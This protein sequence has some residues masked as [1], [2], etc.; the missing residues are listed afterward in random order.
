MLAVTLA[1]RER[2][3][4]RLVLARLPV[5]LLVLV[6]PALGACRSEQS[7]PESLSCATCVST[8]P[9]ACAW[10]TYFDGTGRCDSSSYLV[11]G[12][13][14]RITRTSPSCEGVTTDAG[15]RDAGRR[16]DGCTPPCSS[17]TVCASVSGT[18]T[19]LET[20]GSHAECS[21]GC[22]ASLA[23]GQRACAPSMSWCASCTCPDGTACR[24]DG[25]CPSSG[26]QD[27]TACVNFALRSQSVCGYP[28]DQAITITNGCSEAV[29]LCWTSDRCGGSGCPGGCI[30]LTSGEVYNTEECS[31]TGYFCYRAALTTD[32][33]SCSQNPNDC[34]R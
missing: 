29:H 9:G 31:D 24:S 7:C 26:C 25:S 1:T 28:G 3:V 30:D 22:C 16:P 18:A 19:C 33:A 12:P 10:L 34:G 5:L 6:V 2:D 20:C 21:S 15:A 4:Q 11:G 27:R 8:T 13:I 17:G 14:T 32:P 23:T